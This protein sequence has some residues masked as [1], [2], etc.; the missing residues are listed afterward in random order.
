MIFSGSE[1]GAWSL[2]VDSS[3]RQRP[4]SAAARARRRLPC[5]LMCSSCRMPPVRAGPAPS[6]AKAAARS[7]TCVCAPSAA[8]SG[9]STPGRGAASVPKVTRRIERLRK[10]RQP[11]LAKEMD[12]GVE[13]RVRARPRGGAATSVARAS[14][15]VIDG[16]PGR[17]HWFAVHSTLSALS[18]RSY[19]P[20]SEHLRKVESALGQR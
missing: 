6:A 2:V 11:R 19:T 4:S 13:R 18:S 17:G 7:T 15:R 14:G 10:I 20:Q 8:V 9:T 12:G 5:S 1:I 3:T 16:V